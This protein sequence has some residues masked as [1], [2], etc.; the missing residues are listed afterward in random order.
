MLSDQI[1]QHLF[2]ALIE[3]GDKELAALHLSVGEFRRVQKLSPLSRKLFD[4][5]EEASEYTSGRTSDVCGPNADQVMPMDK[6]ATGHTIP[7]D[8]G[9]SD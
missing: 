9:P 1:A 6:A 3:C 8:P 2:D 7:G 5:L 4:A